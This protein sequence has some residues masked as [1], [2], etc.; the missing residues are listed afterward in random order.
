MA[1]PAVLPSTSS[2]SNSNDESTSHHHP[3]GR[4][5]SGGPMM[6]RQRKFSVHGAPLPPP[7][8]GAHYHRK[9]STHMGDI[10]AKF[11]FDF[12]HAKPHVL[13]PI[14]WENAVG[15]SSSEEGSEG[16]FFVQFEDNS[17]VVIK[18]SSTVAADMFAQD[19][20]H[21]AHIDVPTFR[22]LRLQAD[23]EFATI[24]K[25]LNK[26]D[27]HNALAMRG[28]H[29][30]SLDRPVFQVMEFV[31]GRDLLHISREEIFGKD[32]AKMTRQ[33]V[34]LLRDMGRINSMDV[35]IN[36]WDRLPLIW[37]NKGNAG[38]ML[39]VKDKRTRLLRPVAIDNSV[40]CI[41]SSAALHENFAEYMD[42]V[43]CIFN[44]IASTFEWEQGPL[45]EGVREKFVITCFERQPSVKNIRDFIKANERY[46]IGERGMREFLLGF[47]EGAS[48]FAGLTKSDLEGMKAG[49]EDMIGE[50]LKSHHMTTESV[51]MGKVNI[52][53]LEN[54]LEIYRAALPMMSA[55]L[56]QHGAIDGHHAAPSKSGTGKQ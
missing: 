18:G 22:V 8:P 49:I 11:L 12:E 4:K 36:N 24:C 23:D 32:N 28:R 42:K 5:L 2:S 35:L 13:S 15:F 25:T 56:K 17:A 33:G 37:D 46:D 51:G 20:A 40:T 30:K 19:L 34:T 27:A 10:K 39:F 31:V 29:Q 6:M 21:Y 26:L 52:D 54:I 38:N 43:R 16:V 1:S 7:P 55:L 45:F 53:F 48:A 9:L 47:M 44:E 50:T 14:D 41:D 3:P